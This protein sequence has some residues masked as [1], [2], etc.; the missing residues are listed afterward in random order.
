MTKTKTKGTRSH[1][2]KLRAA[3]FKDRRTKRLRTRRAQSE[4]AIRESA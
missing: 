2:P 4:R 1:S 3:T